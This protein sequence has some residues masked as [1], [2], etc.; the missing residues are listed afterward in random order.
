MLDLKKID[1]KGLT[2]IAYD[3]ESIKKEYGRQNGRAVC[4]SLKNNFFEAEYADTKE[5]AA[6]LILN[7]IPDGA[8]IGCGDSH[9]LFALNLDGRLRE[10]NCVAIPHLYALNTHAQDSEEYG[11]VKIGTKQEMRELLMR[12]LVSDVFML[13]ANAITMDGQIINVDGCGN[14]IAGSLYGPDQI[15]VVAGVNKLVK[16]V[17]AGLERIRFVAAHMNNIKY[18]ENLP[19]QTTGVCMECSSARRCCNI[20]TVIHKKPIDSEFHVIIVGEELGF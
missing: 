11:Y 2:E 5:I 4:K 19:C 17:D 6:D 10:K 1:F 15:I 16:D 14:R 13:S 18:N 9:T 7:L 12:Y 3:V 20:T 8:T